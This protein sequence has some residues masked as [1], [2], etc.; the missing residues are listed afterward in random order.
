MSVGTY[1]DVEGLYLSRVFHEKAVRSALSYEPQPDDVFIVSYPNCGTTWMQFIAYGII[2]NGFCPQDTINFF[3]STPFLELL[4]AE[5]AKDM[6]RPGAIK[7]HLPF[8]KHPY[9]E[10]AKYIYVTRNPYDSCVSFYYHTENFPAYEFD[11]GTFDEFFDLFVRGRVDYGD[12]FDHLLSWYAHR[13]DPNV[14]FVTY[15]DLKK[16]SK[17]WI[18]KV[19]DLIGVDYGKVLKN[20]PAIL[21]R[22]VSTTSLES[23]KS[24]KKGMKNSATSVDDVEPQDVP[25]P[26]RLTKESFGDLSKKPVA[27]DFVRKGI[28]GDWRNHFSPKQVEQM[29]ERITLKTKG[30][31]VMTL[32][33]DVDLP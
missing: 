32:W 17:S 6:T 14:M 30:S 13:E 20:Q 2:N 27:G 28:V 16:D 1:R 21:E 3:R 33:N 15:E 11:D 23:M 7:T 24:T 12:Y 25:E 19:V 5:E 22:I 9:S 8:D 26:F 18:L 4:G 31:D 10:R 29:K